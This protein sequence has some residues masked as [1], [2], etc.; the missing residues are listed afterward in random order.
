MHKKLREE[1]QFEIGKAY[2]VEFCGEEVERGDDAAVGAEAVLLHD[3]LVLDR[4]ADVDVGGVGEA[5][6]GGIQVDEV[7]RGTPLKDKKKKCET[8]EWDFLIFSTDLSTRRVARGPGVHVGHEALGEGRLARAGHAEDEDDGGLGLAGFLKLGQVGAG[9]GRGLALGGR[10]RGGFGDGPGV[11][12]MGGSHHSDLYV[13]EELDLDLYRAKF[14][15]IHL[16]TVM[17]QA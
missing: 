4:L 17:K 15:L 14:N 1:T 6:T 8:F 7:G 13:I 16:L 3:V 10:A 5:V 9:G 2:L 12:G 11:G